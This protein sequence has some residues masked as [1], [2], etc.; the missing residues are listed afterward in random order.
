MRRLQTIYEYFSE[1]TKEQVDEM[2]S[3]L[4]EEDKRLIKLRYGENLDNP[5]GKLNEKDTNKFYGT[6][7]PK[8]KR[9]LK[10][11]TLDNLDILSLSANTSL[12][13]KEENSNPKL[14][15]QKKEETLNDAI[16]EEILSRLPVREAIIVSLKL[17]YVDGKS[18]S[19]SAIAKF[20]GIEEIEVIE[21][22]RKVLLLFKD[23]INDSLDDII[24][25]EIDTERSRV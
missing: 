1:Y 14:D 5:C 24:S 23:N 7:V 19:T 10:K 21:I 25:S 6:L 4:N 16:I 11:I 20:L 13:I 12:A 18:F 17:G 8:M 15:S 22:T 2:L 3:S 9:I